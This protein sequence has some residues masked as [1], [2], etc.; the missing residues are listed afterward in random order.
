MPRDQAKGYG[1]WVAKVVAARK[2]GRQSSETSADQQASERGKW[3]VLSGEPQTDKRFDH[4]IVDRMGSDFYKNVF[5]PAV[6]EARAEGET[7]ESM[8]DR[9]RRRWK[10]ARSADDR[11]ST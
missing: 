7:Y 11:P 4:E 5:A 1:L 9:L 2:F 6:R 8:R 10:P 3:H